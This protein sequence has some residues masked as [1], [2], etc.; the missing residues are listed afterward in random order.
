L[1]PSIDAVSVEFNLQGPETDETYRN[2]Y[3]MNDIR[4]TERCR[5]C[6]Q[7]CKKFPF[8]ELSEAEITLLE[9]ATG[10]LSDVFTN[11]KRKI[12]EEYFLKFRENGYCYFLDEKNGTYT[13]RVYE[14]R[15]DICRTFPSTPIQKKACDN[16]LEKT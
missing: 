15:P 1:T 5:K 9:Q 4:P 10:L 14:C 6:A 2:Y 12:I 7:C 13:C 3:V 16:Y 8:V 11:R